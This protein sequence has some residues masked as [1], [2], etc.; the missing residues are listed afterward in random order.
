MLCKI[1]KPEDYVLYWKLVNGE[2]VRRFLPVYNAMIECGQNP[3]ATL[4][5]LNEIYQI[6]S[7]SWQIILIEI[8]KSFHPQEL[9]I[10]LDT[11]MTL[12]N[13]VADTPSKNKCLLEWLALSRKNAAEINSNRK[14]MIGAML[15]LYMLSDSKNHEDYLEEIQQAMLESFDLLQTPDFWISG[16]V[17][18]I[19]EYCNNC[20]ICSNE[21]AQNEQQHINKQCYCM[22][23]VFSSYMETDKICNLEINTNDSLAITMMDEI[24]KRGSIKRKIR[25]QKSFDSLTNRYIFLQRSVLRL[26]K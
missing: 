14:L 24:Q 2:I 11:D 17:E 22:E 26:L 20:N 19:K 4:I 9:S 25:P 3:M 7:I 8:E 23:K 18:A 12:P 10:L 16:T 6:D 5:D 15:Y 21:T 13:F 1:P